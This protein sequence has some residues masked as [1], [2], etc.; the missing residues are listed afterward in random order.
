[1]PDNRFAEGYEVGFGKP[2]KRNRFR[3]GVSGNPSGRP[4]GRRNL[5]T[6]LAETLQ[7]KVVINEN[8]AQRIITR[9][10]AAVRQLV[11]QAGSGDLRALR[12]LTALLGV[13]EQQTSAPASTG[14]TDSDLKI[15]QNV[16]QRIGEC[17][18][19]EDKNNH[20]HE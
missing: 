11:N 4:R 14:L 6:V 16:V 18:K 2:P 7:E 3:K 10:E 13:A 9:L 20:G 1:V 8:G 17:S 5:T 19:S 15:V 12:H